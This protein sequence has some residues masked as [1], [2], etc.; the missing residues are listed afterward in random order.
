[1]SYLGSI[2]LI[3]EN[4]ESIAE[5]FVLTDE[6]SLLLLQEGIDP[7]TVN[8]LKIPSGLSRVGTFTMLC[9][10]PS[11][12]SFGGSE[13]VWARV[14][15]I[16]WKLSSNY[17]IKRIFANTEMGGDETITTLSVVS[18]DDWRY[19]LNLDNSG[20][21]RETTLN[22]YQD[23]F[24]VYPSDEESQT[25]EDEGDIPIDVA[26]LDE[27]RFHL[28][29]GE[30]G[31]SG[32]YEI[33]S[34]NNPWNAWDYKTKMSDAMLADNVLRAC[35]TIA[36]A[37]P[38]WCDGAGL[39][40]TPPE[41]GTGA[42]NTQW[43]VTEYIGSGWDGAIT[44][45]NQHIG[46]Y[47]NGQLQVAFGTP[48]LFDQTLDAEDDMQTYIEEVPEDASDATSWVGHPKDGTQEIPIG[49]DIQ[50]PAK[51]GNN[52]ILYVFEAVVHGMPSDE[53]EDNFTYTTEVK[54]LTDHIKTKCTEGFEPDILEKTGITRIVIDPTEY[55]GVPGI[56]EERARELATRAL[57]ISRSFYAR[58]Y[59]GT[60][61]WESMGFN[62]MSP[63]SGMLQIEY[64]FRNGVPVTRVSGSLDDQRFG[65]NITDMAKNTILSSGGAM[66]ARPDGIADLVTGSAG[67]SSDL[68]CKITAVHLDPI[69]CIATYNVERISDGEGFGGEFGMPPTD[70]VVGEMCYEPIQVGDP[71]LFA[72]V[73]SSDYDDDEPEE[74]SCDQGGCNYL[75][76]AS[77]N[78]QTIECE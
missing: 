2:S 8:R 41:Y 50:F 23:D 35:G 24:R 73:P 59:A 19:E 54:T 43:M 55:E 62:L 65:F 9:Y 25:T 76:I 29:L 15:P 51:S 78:I 21:S 49:L 32:D 70:R 7:S 58:Y 52:I 74:P 77:E 60:G 14:G 17:R 5:S 47:M 37:Y 63:F 28:F 18:F 69:G 71:V 13:Q 10:L 66:L 36:I 64:F 57:H 1:M 31:K 38:L 34:L 22:V 67:V 16:K 48:E 44:S 33:P 46:S 3:N 42:D 11:N 30:N 61:T 12:W 26:T 56:T 4:E 75:F 27:D 72:F 20:T 68:L 39:Y 6:I 40:Q 53:G 45:W